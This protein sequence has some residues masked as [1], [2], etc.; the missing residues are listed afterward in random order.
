MRLHHNIAFNIAVLLM[1]FALFGCNSGTKAIASGLEDVKQRSS[2]A[3]ERIARARESARKIYDQLPPL[4]DLTREMPAEH[5]A[6]AAVG[7]IKHLATTI[8]QD[9]VAAASDAKAI[10][11][12][13]AN[14]SK[15]LTDVDDKT[16]VWYKSVR[17]GAIIVAGIAAV[18]A[19]YYTGPFIR[20]W[21]GVLSPARRSV[22]KL[23]GETVSGKTDVKETVA[24]WRAS[25]PANDMAYRHE[26]KK[27]ETPTP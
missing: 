3:Q 23:M 9:A 6:K 13:A 19:L 12:A 24:A 22:A 4:E 25:D 2:L 27:N 5:P 10:S 20:A 26:A 1:V 17:L 14:A 8:E 21:L 18:V 16:P 11:E 15:S 7:N